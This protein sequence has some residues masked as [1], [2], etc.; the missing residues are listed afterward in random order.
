MTT[1]DET[2]KCLKSLSGKLSKRKHHSETVKELEEIIS[3]L[4]QLIT[5]DKKTVTQY[6]RDIILLCKAYEIINHIISTI[7]KM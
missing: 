1:L 4:E 6:A 7:N 5:R 2:I 3:Q